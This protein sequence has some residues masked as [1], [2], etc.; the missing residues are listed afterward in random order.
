MLFPV[1]LACEACPQ[2][3]DSNARFIS[4][5]QSFVLDVA[6]QGIKGT[7]ASHKAHAIQQPEARDFL[8][9]EIW[10]NQVLS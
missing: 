1:V 4:S 2:L 5:Q 8:R 9:Q 7:Y 10:D 6:Q 3:N